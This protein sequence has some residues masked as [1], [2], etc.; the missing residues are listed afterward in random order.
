MITYS[1]RY[2]GLMTE[3]NNQGHTLFSIN[4]VWVSSNDVEVQSIIDS[5]D[6]LIPAR[7]E[8]KKRIVDQ[9][10]AYMA[11]VEAEYPSFEKATWPTQK[12]EVEAW[13]IDNTSPT[14][15]LDNIAIARG[16]DR[17]TILSKTLIKVVSY[18]DYAASLAGKR[19]K[20]E[21][22]IDNSTDL[23]FISSIN[24]EA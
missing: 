16:M 8:A 10:Q 11:D 2:S 1:S 4:G 23:D 12:A 14:P 15:M 13:A 19:Q 17:I 5:F 22:D 21:D 7:V 20:L 9:S 18:N 3:I 6:E 24:F